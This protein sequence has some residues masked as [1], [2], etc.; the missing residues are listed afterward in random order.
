[1]AM[2][3]GLSKLGGD[4]AERIVRRLKRDHPEIA[5]QLAPQRWHSA[6]PC[7]EGRSRSGRTSLRFVHLPTACSLGR[8]FDSYSIGFQKRHV[9]SWAMFSRTLA[10]GVAMSTLAAATTATA[11][12]SASPAHAS[13]AQASP[14]QATPLAERPP[15]SSAETAGG[16]G[17]IIRLQEQRQSAVNGAAASIIVVPL[18]GGVTGVQSGSV[19]S[20][21]PSL[22]AAS[23]ART[24]SR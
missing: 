22:R 24:R 17:V 15:T 6:C 4:S 19:G 13:P 20:V 5:E 1:V 8:W 16:A 18:S 11:Q 23:G 9:W 7:C 3:H 21:S 12:H 2:S 14:Q 10:F